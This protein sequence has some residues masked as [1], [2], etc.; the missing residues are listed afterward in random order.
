MAKILSPSWLRL[1]PHETT[2]RVQTFAL[3]HG[4][5]LVD[6][7]VNLG[8]EGPGINSSYLQ[9]FFKRTCFSK[10]FSVTVHTEKKNEGKNKGTKISSVVLQA[11]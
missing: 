1:P 7:R 3:G 11:K 8:L 5:D 2:S 9:S 10:L 6:S 4:G